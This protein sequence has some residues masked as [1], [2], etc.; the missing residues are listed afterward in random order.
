MG[1]SGNELLHFLGPHLTDDFTELDGS[2]GL[3]DLCLFPEESQ[4]SVY[5]WI[6]VLDHGS[7]IEESLLLFGVVGPGL[8]EGGR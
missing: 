4:Q 8:E 1:K 5:F 3:G 6:V 7:V 2:L